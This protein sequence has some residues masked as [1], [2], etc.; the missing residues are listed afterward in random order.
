MEEE[1]G[2][3][4]KQ[5]FHFSNFSKPGRD[6]REQDGYP[7][8]VISIAY[9]ALLPYEEI[10]LVPGS[11]AKHAD[12]YRIGSVPKRK[13]AFPD[14]LNIINGGL[15]AMLGRD[16]TDRL[17]MLTLNL[18]PNTFTL[19]ELYAK[20]RQIGVEMF[21]DK[22]NFHRYIKKKFIDKHIIAETG[23]PQRREGQMGPPTKSYRLVKRNA[24]M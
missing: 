22:A 11:D 2:I 23:N 21:K 18:V 17:L 5:I 24:K 3:K 6:P 10:K 16:N 7:L 9:V 1:I 20:C 15:N 13:L 8:R 14:H 12:F 19:P 4:T